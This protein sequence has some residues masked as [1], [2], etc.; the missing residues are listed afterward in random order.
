MRHVF[1]TV[2]TGCVLAVG[3]LFARGDA[4]RRSCVR[5][6]CPMRRAKPPRCAVVKEG[7]AD[8]RSNLP[9]AFAPFVRVL[10]AVLFGNMSKMAHLPAVGFA[11]PFA[12]AR[13][14]VSR[15]S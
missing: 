13:M 10:S 5:S 6:R 14:R 1:Y 3:N 12:S 7:K 9:C 8:G 15:R 11:V 4:L 2:G